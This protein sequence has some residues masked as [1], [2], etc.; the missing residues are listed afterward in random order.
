MK[1]RKTVSKYHVDEKGRITNTKPEI[2]K[3]TQQALAFM[4]FADMVAN[5]IDIDSEA[6]LPDETKES[7]EKHDTI[8]G[9]VVGEFC[10]DT[11]EIVDIS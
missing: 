4:A 2:S 5:G 7:E 3:T 8:E 6:V 9:E 11:P 1:R 10:D